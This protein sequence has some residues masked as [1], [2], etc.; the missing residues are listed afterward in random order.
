M[1]TMLLAAMDVTVVS[2]AV[3]Q[4]VADLGGFRLFSWVF[5]IFLLTQTVTIP[6]YGKLS[7]LYGR[8]PVLMAGTVVFLVGSVAC[9]AAWNMES[10]ILFRAVQGIGAGSIMATV[11]TLA[12]DLFSLKERA[13]VQGWLSS[14]WGMSAILG[15]LV[16]GAFA[17][18]VSW[19]WIFIVNLPLGAVSLVL[20]GRFLHERFERRQPRIDYLGAALVLA[21]VGTLIFGVLQGGITWPWLS[22]PSAAT[23]GAAAVLLAVTVWAES[24]APEPILPRWVWRRRTLVASNL[25]TAALGVAVMMPNAYLP[26]FSQSVQG[27]GAIAAGLV[28]A[29]MSLGWPTASGLSGRLYLRIGFRDTALCGATLMVAAALAFQFMPGPPPVWMLVLDQ[30]A[31]GAGFGL[32]STPLLV[33]VQSVVGWSERGVVTSAN[34]FARYLG[35]SLGAALFG[36]IFNG[37]VAQRLHTAPVELAAAVPH[38][39]DD[40]VA[41]LHD[42]ATTPAA[43]GYLRAAIEAATRHQYAAMAAVGVLMLLAT[44]WA[45]RRFV[46]VDVGRAG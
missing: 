13:A 40:V 1:C 5:S 35:A 39:V 45:P 21:A 24:R 16:G 8:K 31:L 46:V 19:R 22:W 37:V 11:A 32:L 28:L 34:M 36:A 10:L 23:F 30:I 20:I 3:P 17:E 42:P 2:T 4:I 7:D 27:L 18:Y 41:A 12:G 33:G 29:S 43:A 14:V 38:R 25:A 9:A 15:P 26:V 44:W 6:V